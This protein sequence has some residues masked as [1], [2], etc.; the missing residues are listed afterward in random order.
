MA[1][2]SVIN[3]TSSTPEPVVQG[4]P[5]LV[6]SV[7]AALDPTFSTTFNAGPGSHTLSGSLTV[8][9]GLTG[10]IDLTLGNY[11]P[12]YPVTMDPGLSAT[13]VADNGTFTVDPTLGTVSDATFQLNGPGM[14]ANL[15]L[16][17]NGSLNAQFNYPSTFEPSFSINTPF[18]AGF[19]IPTTFT[20]SPVSGVTFA[21]SEP[22]SFST[23]SAAGT[24]VGSLPTLTASGTDNDFLSASLNFIAL[25]EDV[26]PELSFLGKTESLDGYSLGY[27]LISAPLTG[28]LALDQS[29]TLTPTGTTTV[30]L[31]DM[32]NDQKQTGPLGS[33]FTFTAPPTGSGTIPINATYTTDLEV[34]SDTGIQANLTFSIEGPTA[35][36]SLPVIGSFSIGPLGSFQAFDLSTNIGEIPGTPFTQSLSATDTYDVT[37]GNPVPCYVTGTRILTDRGEVAIEALAIGDTVLT[38][39][40]E[41]RRV[42]WLGSRRIDCTRYPDPASVWPVCIQAGAF[43]PD[44]PARDLWVSPGHSLLV[45]GV[46]IQAEKLV[47]GATIAQVPRP[48]IEYWHVELDSHDCIL[49]EGLPA[50]SYLDTGNRTAFMNGGAFLEA[51]P[52]FRAKDWRETC[53][54]LILEGPEI[55]NAKAALLARTQALGY[56]ITDDADVHVMADGQR[57]EPVRFGAKRMAFMLPAAYSSIELRCRS[58]VPAHTEPQSTDQRAL[59]LC[60]SRLEIDGGHVPL[61]DGAAFVRG[62]HALEHSADGRQR[63]WTQAHTPLP[64]GTRLLVLDLEL[65]SYCWEEPGRAAVALYG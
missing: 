31:E 3:F 12:N 43:A 50:E 9:A 62:W 29:L 58:F 32:L 16:G 11:T 36:G 22:H 8:S 53:V 52:D 35:F 25:A 6:I 23:T 13:A 24:S 37:Y 7:P 55:H 59:G 63:R 1:Q 42:R 14:S 17:V 38:A 46:L 34:Q 47:N 26:V 57:I 49:A 15:D 40:G 56:A 51:Y 33:S 39:S 10:G 27:S 60:V 28:G 54:P 45:D 41:S 61:E 48:R 44:R 21:I 30:S 64:A 2:T 18:N 65:R 5:S 19:S 20:Y 4:A